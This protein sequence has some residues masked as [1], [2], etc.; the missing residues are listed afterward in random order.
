M[1]TESSARV[2]VDGP[3]GLEFH[4]GRRT[5]ASA[6][7][8]ALGSMQVVDELDTSGTAHMMQRLT[9]PVGTN[10]YGLGERFVIGYVSN[11]DHRRENQELLVEAASG[12]RA[13]LPPAVRAC[14]DDVRTVDDQDAHQRP[15]PVR[16]T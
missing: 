16:L 5:L 10:V 8:T 6:G 13:V 2:T 4:A 1:I 11:L 7:P 9:L 14:T 12:A 15:A 3:W